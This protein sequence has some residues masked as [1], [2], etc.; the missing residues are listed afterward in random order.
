MWEGLAMPTDTTWLMEA[1]TNNTL[2]CVTGGSYNL[3]KAPDICSAG[4]VILHSSE[5][6]HLG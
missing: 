1:V 4:W 3:K 6:A 2:V 5:T